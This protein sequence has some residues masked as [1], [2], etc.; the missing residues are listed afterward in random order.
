MFMYNYLLCCSKF[1][2]MFRPAESIVREN[3]EAVEHNFD[4]KCCRE[5]A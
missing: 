1:S 3:T 2:Y 5:C 4:T